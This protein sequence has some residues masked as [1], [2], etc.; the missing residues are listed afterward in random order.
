[1]GRSDKWYSGHSSYFST[2]AFLETAC[3]RGAS[4][5]IAVFEEPQGFSG[6]CSL[7]V[8]PDYNTEVLCYT[9][10][11]LPC[12]APHKRGRS[13]RF[14]LPWYFKWKWMPDAICEINMMSTQL[15]TI[16]SPWYH[17][18]IYTRNCIQSAIYHSTR[19]GSPAWTLRAKL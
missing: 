18:L 12:C 4:I 1:M 11:A 2:E 6:T 7:T 3:C 19:R 15:V 8:W 14:L 5:N 16:L 10:Y 17:F 9:E 13:F